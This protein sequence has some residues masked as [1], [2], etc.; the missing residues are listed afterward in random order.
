MSGWRAIA[1]SGTR[2]PT[3]SSS[4]LHLAA[5][6]DHR[7]VRAR[8]GAQQPV[9]SSA[10]ASCGRCSSCPTSSRS[11]PAS[12]S[13][14][15]CS[16]AR[17]GS[18][19]R[20]GSSAWANPPD[21][22]FDTTAIYPG[23]VLIGIWGI[24]AGI[25]IN[26]AG[27]R[28]IP[29]ELYEA[30]RIDGAGWWA[31]LRN[32]TIPM[33]SPILFYTLIL[34]VIEVLQYFLVPL[35]LKNGTGEPAGRPSSS[36]STCTRRSSRSRS[37]RTGRRWRG[38]CSASPSW[39]PWSCSGCR[40]G[41]STTRV[42]G[43]RRRGGRGQLGRARRRPIARAPDASAHAAGGGRPASHPDR[44]HER[45][46]DRVPLPARLQRAAL[47][48]V[49]GADR[50]AELADP[51]VRPAHVR[52]RGRDG[53]RLLRADAGRH[54]PRARADQEGPPPIGFHRS[55][56]PRRRADHLAG[57]VPGALATVD[58]QSAAGAT[59]RRSGTTSTSRACCSTRW[60]WR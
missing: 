59:T 20:S 15:R 57:L 29:T 50:A 9:S 21:W 33:M 46:R 54:D 55:G 49:G 14:T 18:T 4:P 56:Q 30:A 10:R 3:P 23:L 13:G 11:W 31:Q 35:V 39:S 47:A 16:A 27:L 38:C 22:L 37:C 42:S 51:A 34:G 1:A 60:R 28:G 5:G 48:Q 40:G 26:M 53:E 36:T 41:T 58:G 2:S 19:P 6:L 7:A 24:G 45:D 17:A 43:E 12:S 25:I 32:V 44:R 52:L 8:P